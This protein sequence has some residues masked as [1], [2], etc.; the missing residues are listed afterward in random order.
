MEKKKHV[1]NRKYVVFVMLL[2]IL[3]CISF[4]AYKYLTKESP[5]LVVNGEQV[6]QE[7]YEFYLEHYAREMNDRD[8][9]Q[10]IAEKKIEQQL[11]VEKGTAESFE[12]EKL[13]QRMEE[14]NQENKE[15]REKGEPVYGLL[16]YDFPQF[17]DYEYNN[18]VL[19]LKE[20]LYQNELK[21]T[22]E[23]IEKFY[24]ENKMQLFQGVPEG[25]YYIFS[26]SRS[27]EVGKMFTEILAEKNIKQALKIFESN[28]MR[29]ADVEKLELNN[30]SLRMLDKT[31][32]QIVPELL[33][34]EAKE[35]SGLIEDDY[36]YRILY[37]Q[38]K[39][40]G[41]VKAL[42][43]VKETIRNRVGDIKYEKYLKAKKEK[44]DIII[45]VK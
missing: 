27:E 7:E 6:W 30:E 41:E 23:E 8:K 39:K 5:V 16:T 29:M 35:W 26:G 11:A 18:A 31:N 22:D 13:K 17:Y 3:V 33:L 14:K 42:E 40:E 10:F 36:Q 9:E 15:K 37:C 38:T 20:K 45:N 44:A 24:E 4:A 25:N 34:L 32:H 19:R 43:E 21:A 1:C 2:L 12:F 28:E